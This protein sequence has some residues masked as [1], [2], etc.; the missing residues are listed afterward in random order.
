LA[1]I[2]EKLAA[3]RRGVPAT[4]RIAFLNAG[5]HGPLTAAA[6]AIIARL[7]EEEVRD[8]RL[9]SVHFQRTGELKAATREQFAR[10]LGCDAGEVAL[11]SST[12]AGM[13]IACWG[14]NWSPGDEAVTTVSMAAPASSRSA[15]HVY[16]FRQGSSHQNP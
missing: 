7:A 15:A 12:T 6:G 1:E 10:V 5:S 2:D 11:T 9:G 8:G 16:G 4:E 13:N 14:L 3:V